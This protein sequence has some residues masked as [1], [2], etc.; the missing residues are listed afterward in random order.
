[1]KMSVTIPD[2]L[3][4]DATNWRAIPLPAGVE[5]LSISIQCR[6]NVDVYIATSAS[7]S[8]NY[9]T[10]KANQSIEIDLEIYAQTGLYA[11]S[12]SGVVYLEMIILKNFD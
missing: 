5:S 9:W 1:M 6:T 12:S 4:L 8:D 7:P 3:S 11:R 2:T 10:I